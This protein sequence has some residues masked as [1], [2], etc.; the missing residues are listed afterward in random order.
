MKFN[1]NENLKQKAIEIL[2]EREDKAAAIQEV[3]DLALNEKYGEL[4]EEIQS[5]AKKAETDKEYAKTLGLRNLSEKE[6]KFYEKVI[7]N[8]ALTANQEDIIPTS[9]IDLT[10]ENVRTESPI[11]NLINFA[12]ADVKRWIVAD[13]TGNHVW[14]SLTGN[15]DGELSPKIESLVV[16]LSKLTVYLVIPKAIRDLS[17][18]FVDKY[19]RAVLE[20]ELRNGVADG[21]LNGEGKDQPIGI[22]N[23][24]KEVDGSSQKN[25]PKDTIEVKGFSP[26]QLAPVKKALTNDGKRTI[27]KIYLICNPADEADYVAPALYDR[28]GNMISSYKNL[29]VISEPM[30]KQGKAIFT[31]AGK[32]TMGFSGFNVKEYD[33][34]KAMEDA[35][36]L[37]GKA[38]ANGRAVDDNVAIA[39]DVTKLEE[40]IPEIKTI[41]P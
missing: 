24:I 17:L 37:I 36:V 39:I 28:L 8:Q 12:P 9:I 7:V 5:A 29:E 14:G 30:N 4:I 32:Y 19:F 27:D 35:D 31:I 25:K 13:K 38:Y 26:K 10:L 15:I 22:Y 18:P 20:E 16:E 3:I 6:T 33:Q 40:F 21:Y 34:T 11:L 23:K 41:T 2:N 1:E